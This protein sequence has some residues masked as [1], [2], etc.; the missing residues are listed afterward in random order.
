MICREISSKEYVLVEEFFNVLVEEFFNLTDL[1]SV[2]IRLSVYV[3][4]SFIF[5]VMLMIISIRK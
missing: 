5:I 1:F 3:D 2:C 4:V